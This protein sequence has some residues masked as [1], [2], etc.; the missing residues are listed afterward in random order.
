MKVIILKSEFTLTK[1]ESEIMELLWKEKRPLSGSEIIKLSPN[2]SWKKG[3]IFILLNSLLKK[4]AIEVGGLTRSQTNYGRAFAP[5]L[6]ANDY[7]IMQINVNRK[8]QNL[9]MSDLIVGMI[10]SEEID[11]TVI[12]EL[13]KLLQ[14]KKKELEEQ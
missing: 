13:E 14:E 5:T 4:K 7:A 3:S 1:N 10:A 2:K 9:S 11:Q 12:E 8:E 6:S